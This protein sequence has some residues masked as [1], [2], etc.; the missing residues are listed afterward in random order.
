MLGAD[1]SPHDDPRIA[2]VDFLLSR[3]ALLGQAPAHV[4]SAP[5]R[6][7][8][9]KQDWFVAAAHRDLQRM[10]RLLPRSAAHAFRL[11]VSIGLGP[12]RSRKSREMPASRRLV[13][14]RARGAI[15]SATATL[16]MSCFP[17]DTPWMPMATHSIFITEPQTAQLPSLGPAFTLCWIGWT[18][19]EVASVASERRICETAG[20][21]SVHLWLPAASE[22]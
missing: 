19:T 9:C 2:H 17:V 4:G 8:G 22:P 7:V 14:L 18:P 3:P 15:T 12:L 1:S 21:F 13:D 16:T 10:A 20:G 6:L 11:P 5:R